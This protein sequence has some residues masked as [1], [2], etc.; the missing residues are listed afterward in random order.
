LSEVADLKRAAL[1]LER[2][3][4]I[5]L[6]S[7]AGALSATALEQL[8]ENGIR[9]TA[10]PTV[11]GGY[12]FKGS[13]WGFARGQDFAWVDAGWNEA[14]AILPAGLNSASSA[15]QN[16]QAKSTREQWFGTTPAATLTQLLTGIANAMKTQI[17]GFCYQGLGLVGNP[18]RRPPYNELAHRT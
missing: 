3:A 9:K 1:L 8:I 4:A 14:E 12:Y 2:L 17:V 10:A 11:G 13:F 15:T 6:G 5:N 18:A 7:T 16:G